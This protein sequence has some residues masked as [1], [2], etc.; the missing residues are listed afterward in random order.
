MKFLERLNQFGKELQ[1]QMQNTRIAKKAKLTLKGEINRVEKE[2][3]TNEDSIEDEKSSKEFDPQK[4]WKLEKQRML[5]EKEQAYYEELKKE[6][7]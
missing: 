2:L 4:L 6:L 7:F 1:E 5:L 3:Q